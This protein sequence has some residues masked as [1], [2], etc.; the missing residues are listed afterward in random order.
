MPDLPQPR[1]SVLAKLF[2]AYSV[3][4]NAEPLA[5]GIHKAIMAA[6][7]EVDKGA[8]RKTLQRHTA[9]TKYLKSVASGGTRFGLDGL[10]AGD[11]TPEQQQ[12]A[13]QAVKDRFRKLAE[14][15][16]PRNFVFQEMGYNAPVNWKEKR[17]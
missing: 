4:R 17:S 7:P 6:H 3:F 14:L 2:A 16:F 12:Q 13:T 1:D 5:T 10:P 8:L 11:I 9:S 15:S